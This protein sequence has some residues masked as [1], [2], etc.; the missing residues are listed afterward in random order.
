MEFRIAYHHIPSLLLVHALA[1]S[2]LRARARSLMLSVSLF[3]SLSLSLSLSVK[4]CINKYYVT[5]I[6]SEYYIQNDHVIMLYQKYYT[7]F[8]ILQR[9]RNYG[10]CIIS[11]LQ[12]SS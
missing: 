1:F 6:S 2:L 12:M 10:Y 8:D 11:N 7:N 4:Y 3:L 9:C 5:L